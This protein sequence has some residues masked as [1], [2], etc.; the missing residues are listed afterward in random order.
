[1]SDFP[2]ML[3]VW[4]QNMPKRTDSAAGQIMPTA[5]SQ[6]TTMRSLRRVLLVASQMLFTGGPA[7]DGPT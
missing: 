1:M 4:P 5:L 3:G 7:L 2:T 6:F